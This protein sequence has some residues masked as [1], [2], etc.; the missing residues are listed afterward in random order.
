MSV[1]LVAVNLACSSEPAGPSVESNATTKTE[2]GVPGGTYVETHKI[3]AN[4]VSVEPANRLVVLDTPSGRETIM[5][6]PEVINFD[7]I[8]AGDRVTATV[9]EQLAVSMIPEGTVAPADV[10]GSTTVE[11]AP[12]GAKPGGV[13]SGTVQVVATVTSIDR[14][15]RRATLT[16]ADG[17]AHVVAVRDDIDLTKHKV[18]EKVLIRMTQEVALSVEKQ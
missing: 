1:S 10:G 13:V 16:Y 7:K 2:P 17:S 3:T 6:G 18:G 14:A 15:K 4:V 9:T 11:L 12:K 8:K 5:C